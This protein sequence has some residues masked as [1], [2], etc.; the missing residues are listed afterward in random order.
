MFEVS[1]SEMDKI[2]AMYFDVLAT[3]L[4]C[5]VIL[6]YLCSYYTHVKYLVQS[7]PA[8]FLNI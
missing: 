5:V 3:G 1:G 8:V 4:E 2:Q 7:G 6:L